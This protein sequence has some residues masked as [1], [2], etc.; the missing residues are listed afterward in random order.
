VLASYVIIS[1]TGL[2][3]TVYVAVGINLL[4]VVLLLRA[5]A[6]EARATPT[7]ASAPAAWLAP[8]LGRLAWPIVFATGFLAIGY[9][10]AW[11]RLIGIL[12]KASPYAFSTVL[13][14]Y[15]LGIAWGSR[16]ARPAVQR[17]G[18]EARSVFFGLQGAIGLYLVVSVAGYYH[19]TR[20]TA[21]GALTRAS[22]AV[23]VHPLPAWPSWSSSGEFLAGAF[24]VTDVLVWPVWFVLVPTL[25]MGASFPLAA[26]LA[27]VRPRREGA[28]VGTIYF[29]NVMGNVLGAALTGFLLLPRLGTERTLL[30]FAVASLLLGACAGSFRGRPLPTGVRAAAAVAVALGAVALWPPPGGLYRTMHGDPGPGFETH[31]E[32][33][34]NGVVVTHVRGEVVANYID[35]LGHGHRPGLVYQMMTLEALTWAPNARRALVIGYGTGSTVELLLSVPEVERVTLVE[36]NETLLRNLRKLP[37]FDAMLSDPRLEVIVDDGRRYLL[38]SDQSF[39]LVLMDPLRST[40]AYSNNLYSR[41]FFELAA[42][43]LAPDG[44]LMV[45]FDEHLVIP[46]TLATVLPHLRCYAGFCL[47]SS[48]PMAERPERRREI[49]ERQPADVRRPLASIVLPHLADERRVLHATRG[50]PINEDWRPVSEYY[51]GLPLR[52]WLAGR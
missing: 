47:A 19:L 14:V 52:R 36:L 39:D 10:I 15:L 11:F 38:R 9:E 22:F 4:L 44:V 8:E 40:T 30:G 28:T 20:G 13:A 29:F 26:S 48:E 16:A 33:G 18:G 45:W 41:Q 43:R 24:A 23:D 6:L 49:L 1:W 7:A 2:D 51:L 21:L 25:L 42:R 5:N 46:R 27:L 35:G 34:L 32:E 17:L 3:T 37:V 12:V 31:V 50:Y